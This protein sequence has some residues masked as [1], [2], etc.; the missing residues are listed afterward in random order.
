MAKDSRGVNIGVPRERKNIISKGEKGKE[1]FLD[2]CS[3]PSL[4]YSRESFG[5]DF[6][7]SL[8]V[9]LGPDL[10]W[11]V[12]SRWFL[13]CCCDNSWFMYGLDSQS[14]IFGH[15]MVHFLLWFRFFSSYSVVL[16]LCSLIYLWQYFQNEKVEEKPGTRDTVCRW[17][18]NAVQSFYVAIHWNSQPYHTFL[19]STIWNWIFGLQYLKLNVWAS[20]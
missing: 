3:E 8:L 14:Y 19:L 15:L 10:F 13:S 18:G 1:W 17:E 20:V 16:L 2:R 12:G 11:L 5:T 6:S 9:F 4:V 7:N